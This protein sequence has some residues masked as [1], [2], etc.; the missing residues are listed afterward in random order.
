MIHPVFRLSYSDNAEYT[1]PKDVLYNCIAWAVGDTKN[2]WEPSGSDE[3]FWP[4]GTLNDYTIKSLIQAYESLGYELCDNDNFE[5]GYF[6]IAIF[7]NDGIHYTHA[8]KQVDAVFWSSK[9][10]S[11]EDIK[12][13]LESIQNGIYG[14]SECF[15]K[16]K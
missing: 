3:D 9:L 15:M 7:S 10:G 16:K 5:E 2:W 14:K 1:S 11:S 6:K 13:T 12:H 8:A 4:E